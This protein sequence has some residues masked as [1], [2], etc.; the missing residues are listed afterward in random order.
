VFAGVLVLC[1]APKPASAGAIYYLVATTIQGAN[2]KIDVTATSTWDFTVAQS[3]SLGGGALVMK[4]GSNTSDALLMTLIDM[5]DPTQTP[6]L[7]GSYAQCDPGSNSSNQVCMTNAQFQA[8]VDTSGNGQNNDQSFNTQYLF[9]GAT[10]YSYQ[11]VVTPVSAFT[12][13]AGHSY[14][15]ELTSLEP[16]NSA[17][18]IKGDT[19]SSSFSFTSDPGCVTAGTCATDSLLPAQ[20][21]NGSV[22]SASTAPEPTSF[23]LLAG[24]LSLLALTHRKRART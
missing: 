17:Y 6:S 11:N 18:F 22:G 24:A 9:L 16:T 7:P 2:T 20:Y 14:E 8:E 10:S 23:L 1:F 19:G 12:L 3:F 15:L 4:D 21:L 13:E 5:T